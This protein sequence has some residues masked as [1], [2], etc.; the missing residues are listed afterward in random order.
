MRVAKS[1]QSVNRHRS[2]ASKHDGSY[3]DYSGYRSYHRDAANQASRPA[4]CEMG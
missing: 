4:R 3:D 2:L 1:Q